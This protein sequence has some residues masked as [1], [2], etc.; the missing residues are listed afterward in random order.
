VARLG[1]AQ[2]VRQWW[3]S[4]ESSA[5]PEV[6]QTVAGLHLWLA[7]DKETSL[8]GG[9]AVS[10]ATDWSGFGN[11]GVQGNA[12]GQPTYQTGVINGLPVY[13]F[14]G[15]NDH[16][17]IT[18]SDML[19]LTNNRAGITIFAVAS[20]SATAAALRDIIFFSTG[21]GADA[22]RAKIGQ[23]AT[24]SGVW[25][26]T[27][28]RNDADAIAT[29]VGGATQ[30]GVQ[31]LTAVLNWANSDATLYRNGSVEA[32]TT[33]FLTDGNTQP[34]NSLNVA[35]G[36]ASFSTL[37]PWLGDIAEIL[38]Y[39]RAL[40]S[41]DRATVEAYLATKYGLGGGTQTVNL[42]LTSETETAQ[43]NTVQKRAAL[44]L[45]SET[46]TGQPATLRRPAALGLTV[47]TETAQPA[48]TPRIVNLGR[49][50][51]TETAQ[52]VTTSA[53]QQIPLGLTSETET[54]RPATAR[55][56][57]P[58][59]YHGGY[60]V[61]YGTGY[62]GGPLREEESA[63][64]VTPT[65]PSGVLLGQTL[66]TETARPLT[67]RYTKPVGLISETETAQPAIVRK[68]AAFTQ[69]TETETGQ[70]VTR[71]KLVNF[72]QPV[73][74]ETARPVTTSSSTVVP[75]GFTA[76]TETAQPAAARKVDVAGFPVETE[77]V[78]AAKLVE[79]VPLSLLAEGESPLP[80]LVRD[81]VPLT[82]P[83]E[84][85]STFTARL[86]RLRTFGL[87]SETE[88][89]LPETVRDVVPLSRPSELESPHP[90]STSGVTYI[91]LGRPVETETA[92][93]ATTQKI[94]V[95]SVTVETET[96][97][98]A[99]AARAIPTGRP[100]EAETVQPLLLW[101]SVTLS[102]PTETETG[103]PVSTRKQLILAAILELETVPSVL[104]GR[105]HIPPFVVSL[106]SDNHTAQS[107]SDRYSVQTGPDRYTTVR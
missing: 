73:E 55:K 13:R 6:P 63:Q 7:A 16:L 66:E 61:G 79:T 49:P 1:R 41:A 5:E 29:V 77:T 47:E 107:G 70:P 76:E 68:S 35:I 78:S 19:A 21:G 65:T 98:S 32:S 20:L 8:T 12:T 58:I 96:V 50:V 64:T 82:R 67:V 46:E 37:E 105:Q 44:G 51:E 99:A 14:D 38:V 104:G 57:V 89:V 3:A 102:R 10:Q 54:A 30:T 48:T 59:S 11:H 25:G 84:T 18:N 92:R 75:L 94:N 100:V 22:T 36:G 106:G 91:A 90:I 103:F 27:A 24:G 80:L 39:D 2:P 31:Q 81:Q 33:T 34:L 15:S 43:P 40:D 56:N 45:T 87:P 26:I 9:A 17:P 88:T 86:Q 53:V 42:G 72:G 4:P 71:R 28:R 52:T 95:F 60:L 101:R 83:V 62:G 69:P 74:T 93:P 23:R 85:E 97:P